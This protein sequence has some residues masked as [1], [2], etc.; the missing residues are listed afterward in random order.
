MRA[1]WRIG[2]AGRGAR[3]DG[4]ANAGSATKNEEQYVRQNYLPGAVDRMTLGGKIWGY[5]T[6]FQAPAYFYR[7]S[8]YKEAGLNAPPA[9][10]EDVFEH[11][12]KLTRKTGGTY[13]RFGF[14]LNYDNS[15]I[16]SH[17][18]SLIARFGGQMYSFSG[19]RPVKV[20]VASPQALEAV[21]WW[22]RLVEAGLTQVGEQP[23][24]DAYRNGITTATEY[25]GWYTLINL[26]YVGF[27]DIYQ[28]L[29]GAIVAPKRGVKPVV[30]AG[31]WALVAT[32]GSKQ[33]EERWK[34]MQ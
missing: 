26:K 16:S 8:H 7:K 3:A 20:D 32:K 4:G 10:T 34:L 9:T 11:A 6:E 25:E 19:D 5:P 15:V 14:G 1:G 13:S 33:P 22:K 17:L 30:Y 23:L 29:G 18:P 27:E 31:G 12:A 2:R 21:G 28:D 24:L